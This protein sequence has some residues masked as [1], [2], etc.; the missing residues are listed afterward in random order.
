M[1]FPEAERNPLLLVSAKE[2][3]DQEL[4]ATK[5]KLNESENALL[6]KDRIVLARDSEIV[7]LKRLCEA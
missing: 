4:A 3:L 7:G 2:R 5:E 1:M 6:L